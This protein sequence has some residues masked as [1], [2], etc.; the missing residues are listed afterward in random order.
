M[1][2]T[3][4]QNDALLREV[5]DAVRRDDM[6][7]F[8]SRYGR[9]VAG[10]VGV[11]LAGYGGWLF[12]LSHQ[13]GVAERS[14][15]D[16]AVMLKT[17]QGA[18]LDEA[19]YKKL[20]EDGSAGYR[21]EADLVK[22]A[23][24]AGTGDVKTALATY[25]SLR[26]S[27]SAPQPVKELAL[28]RRVALDFDTMKPQAVVDALKDLTVTGNPWFG[29]AGEMTALAYLKMNKRREAAEMF[30]AVNRDEA[31]TGSIR[32]RAGQMAATLGVSPDMIKTIEGEESSGN[33]Q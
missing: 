32:T 27:G 11:L 2:L 3:P 23:I 8:W 20:I 19:N 5:D 31:V 16:F 28:I 18:R 7:S 26:N 22:A 33:A 14:S 24:A 21:S 13:H 29:S 4:E 9:L 25:D 30:A 10:G 17:A 1:A 6:M 15:E 12:W